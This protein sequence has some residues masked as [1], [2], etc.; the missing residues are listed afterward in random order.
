MHISSGQYWRLLLVGLLILTLWGQVAAAV[1]ALTPQAY[2]PLVDKA[3]RLPQE[4]RALWVTRFDWT[5]L[6]Q[7][8]Q[9]A[10]IDEIVSKAAAANFNMIL[11]QVRGTADAYYEPGLEPWAQRVSGH[12][13]GVPPDPFWDPLAYMVSRAHAAGLQVHAY[14]N[15]YPTW[16]GTEPPN[17]GVVP[18]H[19]FWTWSHWPDT[20]WAD[21]RHWYWNDEQGQLVPMPLNSGYLLASP[22]APMVADHIAN[23]AVD[24]VERFK[25]DGVHLDYIRYAGPQYSCDP[26]TIQY[27][28]SPCFT[29][30]WEDWQRGQISAL[31]QRIYREMPP[32][33]MLSAAVWPVYVDRW[34]WGVSEGR[35]DYYQDS[36]AWAQ[37]G[38]VD[39]LM[40][41][42]YPASYDECAAGSFWTQPVWQTLI[43]DFQQHSNG[44]HMIAGIGGGY[45]SFDE[46]AW[47]IEQGRALGTAGHAIFSYGLIDNNTNWD[48]DAFTAPGGPHEKPAAVPTISWR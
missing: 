48:W 33:V 14:L 8:A 31:V 20:D 5:S 25:V 22:A 6:G 19:P 46:I 42:I 39:A 40:P 10:K 18:E 35:D 21:W 47:R 13:L 9:P 7:P 3:D 32:S 44:R 28:P 26:F 17:E 38:I 41:M 34:G 43:T 12:E 24:I 4:V 36:Q 16:S 1:T 29:S 45:C 27:S 2:L 15:V 30:G 37:S 11:F 23:V